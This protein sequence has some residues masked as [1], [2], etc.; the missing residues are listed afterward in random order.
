MYISLQTKVSLTILTIVVLFTFFTLFYFPAQQRK[1][2]LSSY[3][4]EVQNLS[5]T[6]ALGVQIALNEQNYEGV[7]TAMEFVKGNPDLRFVSLLERDTVW[8]SQ[9][10]AFTIK[11]TVFKT[12]PEGLTPKPGAVSN[13]TLII[14]KTPFAT[15]L[16]TGAVMLGFSTNAIN[17]SEED[18][19]HT[20]LLISLG[21][22]V[23]GLFIGLFISRHFSAPVIALHNASRRIAK[24][25]LT[26]VEGKFANDEVGNLA[27]AFNSMITDLANSREE[28]YQANRALSETNASLSIALEDLQRT[29]AQLIQKEKMAS[30]GELTAGI[31]HEI[32]NPLNFVNNFSQIN[33]ELVAELLQAA[34]AGNTEEVKSLAGDIAENER[35]ILVHGQRA[36]SIVKN[37]LQHSHSYSGDKLPIDL[38]ALVDEYIKLAYHGFRAKDS[39]F[40]VILETHF[41]LHAPKIDML[42][43]D[44]GRVLLNLFDNAFYAVHQKK[45]RLNGSFKPR[46]QVYI[47]AKEKCVEVTVKDNGTGI[48]EKVLHKIYQP[49]F[50][51][52]PTGEGTG[53]G[54]SLSYDIIT[55][56]H[57]G[58]LKVESIEGQG[59][60][61]TV[62]LPLTMSGVT[63]RKRS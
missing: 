63:T 53:L 23:I 29:Q 37:M 38:N 5:N 31:A 56:G 35:K 6:V 61:F 51:T 62:V 39:T 20:S 46:V 60:E 42:P 50:T 9:H 16:M 8:N 14:A 48:P 27:K 24:G 13:D 47:R 55:K 30:L 57:G 15:S 22:F 40:N 26:P 7:Q 52:K 1:M 43:Q 45:Q 4:K 25:D 36:D 3:N 10:Q 49:F 34:K 17:K 12:F 32:K 19:F 54:L 18:I 33:A 28:L 59:T 11:E 2:L 41:D 44:I 21:I 58:E